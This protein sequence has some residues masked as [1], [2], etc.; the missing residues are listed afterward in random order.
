MAAVGES[1]ECGT[2]LVSTLAVEGAATYAVDGYKYWG[3]LQ[4]KEKTVN[5]KSYLHDTITS[6]NTQR[7]IWSMWIMINRSRSVWVKTW[8]GN[9][10]SL[11]TIMQVESL[12]NVSVL[13]NT[14]CHKAVWNGGV[15]TLFKSFLL[16]FTHPKLFSDHFRC[17]YTMLGSVKNSFLDS[18]NYRRWQMSLAF[19][20]NQRKDYR[21]AK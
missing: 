9:T 4:E 12:Y 20:T 7:K 5:I 1:G 16:V 14:I 10:W 8:N 21:H 11:I 6:Q 13:A 15:M 17:S 19:P 18:C 3:N 2:A